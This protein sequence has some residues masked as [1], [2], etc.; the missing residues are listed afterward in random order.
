MSDMIKFLTGDILFSKCQTLVNPVNCV[1]VMG[2]G[3]ALRFRKAY[4]DMYLRYKNICQRGLLKPGM[5]WLYQSKSGT[6]V[7]CF[8]TKNDWRKPSR[9]EWIVDGL[10]KF[11]ATYKAKGITSAAFPLLGAGN[12]GLDKSTA[13]AI[14]EEHLR[15]C[16]IPIEIYS[17]YA[18]YSRI[19]IP[20]VERLTGPL[21][22]EQKKEIADKLCHE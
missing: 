9:P 22:E 12:G 16:D 10:N 4:P 13:M 1:G 3:L 14:L 21:S 8:P 5:L 20:L 19:F 7:L 6:K 2:K 11:V 17:T 18:P 15:G